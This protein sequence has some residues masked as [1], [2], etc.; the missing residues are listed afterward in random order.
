MKRFLGP[1]SLLLCLLAGCL[2]GDPNP[3]DRGDEGTGNTGA[4]S[5]GSSSG[6]GGTGNSAGTSNAGK[7]S[8]AQSSQCSLAATEPVSLTFHNRSQRALHVI[9]VDFSCQEKLYADVPAGQFYNV[10]T[11][12]THVWRLRD[13][14]SN[15]FLGEYV[16][17]ATPNQDV[18]I[19][20]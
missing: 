10:S 17:S 11:Y 9:W 2:E 14:V 16:V 13:L 3:Y 6:S 18:D 1:A 19:P 4:G 5:N 15:G 12:A 7:L 20:P 8:F